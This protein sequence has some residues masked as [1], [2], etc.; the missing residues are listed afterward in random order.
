ME[1]GSARFPTYFILFSGKKLGNDE[2]GGLLH[3]ISMQ[4]L[5]PL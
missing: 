5:D 2:G 3:E 1:L 4:P